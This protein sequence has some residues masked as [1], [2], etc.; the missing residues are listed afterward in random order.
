[1]GGKK[2][3]A[4][5]AVSG[6]PVWTE[7][8]SGAFSAWVL[9]EEVIFA[10]GKRGVVA[11]DVSSGAVQWWT[12]A[13]SIGAPAKLEKISSLSL[14]QGALLVTGEEGAFALD[15]SSGALRWSVEMKGPLTEPTWFEEPN[16]LVFC[17][18]SEMFV[19]D[20]GNGK[21]L[22]RATLDLKSK[23]HLLF[24]K[25]PSNRVPFLTRRVGQDLLL[26]NTGVR[27]SGVPFP[28][29]SNIQTPTSALYDVRTGEKRWT[30]NKVMSLSPVEIVR[31]FERQS[32][33]MLREAWE[34]LKKRADQNPGWQAVLERLE[35]FV[36]EAE[37][38]FQPAYLTSLP[39]TK[40]R[41]KL[42]QIDPSTGRQKEWSLTGIQPDFNPAFGLAYTFSGKNLQ[43]FR[44]SGE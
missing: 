39:K 44:L 27:F 38:G 24:I 31:I 41:W 30:E 3:V 17:N 42:W 5:D 1:M 6:E 23:G 14:V 8:R 19:V 13:G 34:M 4:L 35:P 26:V 11:L 40:D 32:K 18:K 43:A 36:Q 9:G 15:A 33:K 37:E 16:S 10:A 20:A 22:R 2:L 28:F 7:E 29:L 25:R 12:E 21:V